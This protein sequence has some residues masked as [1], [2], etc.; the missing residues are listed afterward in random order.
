MT[1]CCSSHVWSLQWSVWSVCLFARV[2]LT[3]DLPVAHREHCPISCSVS[4]ERPYDTVV[5][6]AFHRR[7]T[8]LMS[9]C[10]AF[11]YSARDLPRHQECAAARALTITG[12]IYNDNSNSSTIIAQYNLIILLLASC[13][14]ITLSNVS[15]NQLCLFI[16]SEPLSIHLQCT[17]RIYSD[18][19]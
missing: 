12:L 14:H 9:Q 3:T 19:T 4:D 5:R 6:S 7:L 10:S 18:S 13:K 16:Q 17:C 1:C 15:C 8:R 2:R 11:G